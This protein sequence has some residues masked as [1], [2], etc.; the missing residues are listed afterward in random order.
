MQYIFY[1]P[2]W[3]LVSDH[4][5]FC[6]TPTDLIFGIP[7]RDWTP[8]KRP[9]DRFRVQVKVVIARIGA[10]LQVFE[11]PKAGFRVRG[12]CFAWAAVAGSNHADGEVFRCRKFLLM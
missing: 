12:S 10:A 4:A 11:A 5:K 7:G 6:L 2:D 1:Y 8:P 3:Q 9:V